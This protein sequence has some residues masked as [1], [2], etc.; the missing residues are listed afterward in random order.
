MLGCAVLTGGG[1]VVNAAA[2]R[3]GERVVVVGLGG[4]GMAAV[5]VA[6]ALG[7][8]VVGVDALPSKLEAARPHARGGVCTPEELLSSGERAP[9]V[10]EAAG[11]PAALETALAAA[12]PGGR[13][14]TVGLPRPDARSTIA[15]LR[16]TSEALTL[17]GS[18]LGSSVPGRDVP[19]Y[20]EL[21]RAGRLPVEELISA[22]TSLDRVNEA[23]DDLAEGRALRQL[24]SF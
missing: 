2:P 14:V 11:H 16:L 3:A 4:V 20:V 15:P 23:L 1:A 17:T 10:V 13:V 24:L 9:V 18:Y 19:R 22:T 6:A 5:L 7:H 8:E 12:A 21:W